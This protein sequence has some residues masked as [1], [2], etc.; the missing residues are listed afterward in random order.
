MTKKQAIKE[1]DAKKQEYLR[2]HRNGI[3]PT[4]KR[5]KQLAEEIFDLDKLLR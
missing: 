5:M 2:L 4:N 3:K 1:R